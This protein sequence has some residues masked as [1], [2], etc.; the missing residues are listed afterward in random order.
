M[1]PAE[2]GPRSRPTAR[3]DSSAPIAAVISVGD[4]LL[5]GETVNTNQA[6]LGRALVR[7]G[8]TVRDGYTVGDDEDEI[9]STVA[10]ALDRAEVVIVTGG[11]GPTPDDRTKEAVADL[12]GRE[13]ELRQDLYD[14]L[15]ARFREW[16][17]DR[18]PPANRSQAEVP[19]GAR[20]LR[21][22]RGSAP[23]ILMEAE[24]AT[25]VLL[26]GIPREV[27]AIWKEEL[28]DVLR[29]RFG[30]RLR[31]TFHRMIHTTGIPESVLSDSV[32]EA[33]PDETG[34]VS[35]A[36]LPRSTG[37]D[38]RLSARGVGTEA[39]AEEWLDRIE[40]AIEPVVEGYRYESPRGDLVDAVA[41]ALVD[42][43]RML[44]VAESCT[45]GLVAQRLTD[46]PGS[47][48]YFLGG[49]VSYSNESKIRDLGVSE[50]LLRLHGAVSDD[51]VRAMAEGIT[52]RFGAEAGI[53]IT[54]IAG[55]GGG[56]EEKPVGTV[57]YAS[58]ID[59]ETKSKTFRFGGD[60]Q[61]VRERSAQAALHLLLRG[62]QG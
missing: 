25:V 27:E 24:D 18:L 60:R 13:L 40:A 44:A 57:W 29:E 20:L 35:V 5:L 3:D 54:G 41:R 37:A 9:R 48:D 59:G 56:T 38:L 21:N 6:W 15:E 55:P 11:L 62:L 45:G 39:E 43:G 33:L 14:A 34:P 12:M 58:R 47:S 30:V 22:P 61:S 32:E 26:P 7:T 2:S 4:E 19:A 50:E 17:F 16:G 28:E 23:G 8:L 10:R 49:V 42:S 1:R 52:D 46:R 31:P 51:V 36:F 53:A